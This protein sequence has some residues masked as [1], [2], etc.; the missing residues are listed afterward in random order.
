[1]AKAVKVPAL[2]DYKEVPRWYRALLYKLQRSRGTRA[3][4]RWVLRQHPK[5]PAIVVAVVRQ[6]LTHQY[7][8][9]RKP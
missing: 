3:E 5:L 2:I 4:L 8:D 6:K 1:M 9:K 7:Q